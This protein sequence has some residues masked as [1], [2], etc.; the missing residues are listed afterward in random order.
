[1]GESKDMRAVMIVVAL[2]FGLFFFGVGRAAAADPGE[3]EVGH[4]SRTKAFPVFSARRAASPSRW[5][6][7][8]HASQSYAGPDQF[9]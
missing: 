2:L 9:F 8:A 4:W 1:M 5:V 3:W 6:M 7:A